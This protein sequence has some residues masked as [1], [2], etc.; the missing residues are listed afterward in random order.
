LGTFFG[1]NGKKVLMKDLG[2]IFIEEF[3]EGNYIG[4]GCLE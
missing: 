3:R 1:N 2:I 4:F